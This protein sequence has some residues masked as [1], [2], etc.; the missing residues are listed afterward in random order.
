MLPGVSLLSRR[1]LSGLPVDLAIGFGP[2][3]IAIS[4]LLVS[5]VYTARFAYCAAKLGVKPIGNGWLEAKK[6]ERP[7]EMQATDLE[8]VICW[9]HLR[10]KLATHLLPGRV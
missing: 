3:L 10:V 1:R 7:S 9:S 8:P 6:M 5:A 4:T 2:G